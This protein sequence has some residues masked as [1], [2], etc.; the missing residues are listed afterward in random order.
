L[1][2]IHFAVESGIGSRGSA[3]VL[4]ENGRSASE[5]LETQWRFAPE[6]KDFRKKVLRTIPTVDGEFR[7][8]WLPCRP[9]PQSEIWFE[10]AWAAFRN[11]D[12][13]D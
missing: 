12:I 11:K 3:L 2:A 13:Y 10:T 8:D 9:L 1:N 5:K 4:D 6:N 7:N